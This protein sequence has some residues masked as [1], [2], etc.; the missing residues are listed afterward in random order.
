M[1]DTVTRETE[2]FSN[3]INDQLALRAAG[4]R[5]HIRHGG[6]LCCRCHTRP[7]A[8]AKDRYCKECRKTYNANWR[9]KIKQMNTR[10]AALA[11]GV[12]AAVAASENNITSKGTDNGQ[13]EGRGRGGQKS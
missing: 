8:S 6:R 5:K 13:G 3:S 2:C 9:L 12:R 4:R 10:N 11:D 7:P 1:R